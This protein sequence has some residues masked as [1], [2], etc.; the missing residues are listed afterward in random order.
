MS[1]IYYDECEVFNFLIAILTVSTLEGRPS[2][3][4]FDNSPILQVRSSFPIPN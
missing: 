1:I 4:D 3:I 2:A